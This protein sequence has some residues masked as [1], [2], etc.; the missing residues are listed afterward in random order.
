MPIG[1]DTNVLVRI[2]LADDPEDTRVAT[3]LVARLVRPGGSGVFIPSTVV[4]ELSWVLK[5]KKRPRHSIAQTLEDLLT[6]SNVSVGNRAALLEALDA[7]REGSADF[8]DY[9][10]LAEA[11]IEGGCKVLA[12]FDEELQK[13]PRCL[14]PRK[15]D[16]R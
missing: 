1:V 15:I 6:S 11:E 4:V 8:A 12:T 9:A 14:S 3:D 7:Y 10:I 13:D 2:I 5:M 16:E